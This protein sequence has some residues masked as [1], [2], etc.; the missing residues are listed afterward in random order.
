[1]FN[2]YGSRIAS[3]SIGANIVFGKDKEK[4]TEIKD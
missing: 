2:L 4:Q 3:I 1:M